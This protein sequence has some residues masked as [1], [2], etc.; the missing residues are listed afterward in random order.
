[1]PKLQGRKKSEREMAT[2]KKTTEEKRANAKKEKK[3]KD[4][5]AATLLLHQ[6]REGEGEFSS[7]LGFMAKKERIKN[8][9]T[10]GWGWEGE[11]MMRQKGKHRGDATL[12]NHDN[13]KISEGKEL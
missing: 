6:G 9:E 8:K 3:T 4:R 2:E 11:R 5:E 1:V 13:E 10:W 12:V 7:R